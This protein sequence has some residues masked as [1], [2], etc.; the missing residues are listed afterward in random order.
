MREIIFR[1][2]TKMKSKMKMRKLLA[3][4]LSLTMVLSAVPFGLSAGAEAANEAKIGDTQFA[5]MEEA[6]NAVSDGETITLLTDVNLEKM[7]ATSKNVTLDLGGKTLSSGADIVLYVAEGKLTVKNGNIIGENNGLAVYASLKEEKHEAE[8][9]IESD[10]NI[11]AKNGYGAFCCGG[12]GKTQGYATLK[13]SANITSSGNAA[14]M[15]HGTQPASTVEITGGNVTNQSDIAV[16]NPAGTLKI[17]GGVITG[18]T[19]VYV[20]GGSVEISGGELKATGENAPFVHGGSG[21]TATGDALVIENSSYP[22]AGEN[23]TVSVTGG[24]FASANAKAVASYSTDEEAYPVKTGFVTGGAFSS[25]VT[26]L[27]PAGYDWWGK[28]N[29]DVNGHAV[30]GYK[31]GVDPIT[32][33]VPHVFNE[34]EV[35]NEVTCTENG[36]VLKTCTVCGGEYTFEIPSDGHDLVKIEA[37]EATCTES[38]NV[39]CFY[40]NICKKYF[41]ADNEE[42]AEDSVIIPALEHEFSPDFEKVDPTETEDGYIN[43]FCTVC[44]KVIT[45]VLHNLKEVPAVQPVCGVKDGVKA[46]WVCTNCGKLFADSEGKNETSMDELIIVK[47]AGHKYIIKTVQPTCDEKGYK[48][49]TC[50]I[51]NDSYRDVFADALGHK[52]LRVETKEPD[53]TESGYVRK[54]CKDCGKTIEEITKDALGHD[55][56]RVEDP[57]NKPADCKTDGQEKQQCARCKEVRTE[58][59]EKLGHAFTDWA[60]VKDHEPTCTAA[61]QQER[62]CTRTGCGEKETRKIDALGHNWSKYMVINGKLVRQCK[63]CLISETKDIDQSKYKTI[64][65]EETGISL[66]YYSEDGTFEDGASPKLSIASASTENTYINPDYKIRTAYTVKTVV[67]GKETEPGGPVT[68][69]IPASAGF[70]V[71]K[72][73]VYYIDKSGIPDRVYDVEVKGANLVFETSNVGTFL[74]VNEDDESI[75]TDCECT[76]HS[77]NWFLKIIYNILRFFWKLLKVNQVCECGA[78]HY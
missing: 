39:E 67:D 30:T 33:T 17:T 20:K 14:I 63:R 60:G 64:T 51:C 49:Y 18:A 12:N 5:T 23:L 35:T 77:N 34:G 48:E 19:A 11:T 27:C 26:A 50:E 21:A 72:T 1:R 57:A 70:N 55:W 40:C 3:L 13:T 32:V 56:K 10:V 45:T 8:L 44:K 7:A 69:S 37:K 46:H 28:R 66:T 9:D 78:L 65:D 68:I 71:N 22:S 62:H 75:K 2:K 4:V 36:S 41:N 29:V 53:C 25:D 73:A 31:D 54:V 43:R 16:Y 52:N 38:G 47:P 74:L 59:L 15:S 58:I 76:C 42:L 6:L 61:G 24:S